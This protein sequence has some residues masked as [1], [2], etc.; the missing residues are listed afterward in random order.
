MTTPLFGQ[1]LI[2]EEPVPESTGYGLYSAATVVDSTDKRASMGVQWE[3]SSCGVAGT[4]PINCPGDFTLP[5]TDGIPWVDAAPFG[6]AAGQQCKPVGVELE[7]IQELAQ[8]RFQL[9]EQYAVERAYWTGDVFPDGVESPYLTDPSAEVLH[10]TDP[11]KPAHAV[12]LLEAWLGHQSGAV[13]VIHAPRVLAPVLAGMADSAGGK[14]RTKVG[15]R[16]ALGTGYLGTGPGG[17]APPADTV[18]VYATGPV[19]VVRAQERLTPQNPADALDRSTNEARAHAVRIVS[20]GH[21]CGLAAVLVT[22]T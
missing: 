8:V 9:S 13:G 16:L 3:S 4:Y 18:W 6:V 2:V 20:V 10:G 22:L 12:G 21:A 11:V 14:L 5:L 19:Q 7:R 17:S 1:R 15:T